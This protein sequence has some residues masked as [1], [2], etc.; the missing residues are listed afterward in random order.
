MKHIEKY[1]D[2]EKLIAEINKKLMAVNLEKLG[3]FGSHRVWAYNDVKDIIDSLQQVQPEID[4]KKEIKE[5][6]DLMVGASFPEQDGDFISEED[7]R[8]VIRQTAIH[9][10]LFNARKEDK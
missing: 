3:N 7:Y 8:S 6:T 2:A 5:W 1:I 4:L 9:F 10:L